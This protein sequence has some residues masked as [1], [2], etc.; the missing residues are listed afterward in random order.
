MRVFIYWNLHRHCWSIKSLEGPSRGRV[1][2][3]AHSWEIHAAALKVSEAGRQ[4]VLREQRKNVHAGVVGQLVDWRR[5][6][7]FGELPMPSGPSVRAV[8]YNPYKGPT[9]TVKDTG[10]P[11]LAAL[12]V[13]AAG[14][15]VV[16]DDAH[17]FPAGAQQ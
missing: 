16:V 12:R 10:E 17:Q 3:H 5:V 1:I 2:G 9:F 14:R 8:T 13:V 4:R 15:T 11:I 7:G 6:G